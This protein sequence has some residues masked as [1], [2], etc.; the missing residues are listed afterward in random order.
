MKNK[1]ISL[2]NYVFFFTKK[3]EKT[4]AYTWYALHQFNFF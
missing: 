1:L 2:E 4:Y 3:P